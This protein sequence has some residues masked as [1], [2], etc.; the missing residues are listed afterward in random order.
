MAYDR[1]FVTR[2]F[3]RKKLV[4]FYRK[5]IATINFLKS[6]IRNV[7]NGDDGKRTLILLLLPNKVLIV[8]RRRT[9]HREL[10]WENDWTNTLLQVFILTTRARMRCR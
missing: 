3:V 2:Y 4:P 7:N 6:I 9:T 10:L 5:R 1:S 8:L